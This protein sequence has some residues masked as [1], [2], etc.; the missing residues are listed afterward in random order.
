MNLTLPRSL[1]SLKAIL[2]GLIEQPKVNL[3]AT[4]KIVLKYWVALMKRA[5][6]C[7]GK[8]HCH[9]GGSC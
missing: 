4:D 1:R 3:S 5:L 2:M 6:T 9:V 8:I 7:Y